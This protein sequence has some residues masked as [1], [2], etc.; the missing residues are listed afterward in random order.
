MGGEKGCGVVGGG[1]GGFVGGGGGGGGW[2]GG[3]GGGG[4]FYV[5][6]GCGVRGVWCGFGVGLCFG[7]GMRGMGVRLGLGIGRLGCVEGFRRWRVMNWELM[8]S[9]K[10]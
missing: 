2:I 8:G 10:K 6:V 1:G 5:V 9:D 4:V 7:G 3:G